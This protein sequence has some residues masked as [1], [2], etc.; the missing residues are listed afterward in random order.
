[1]SNSTVREL[2]VPYD[3][4]VAEKLAEA[5]KYSDEECLDYETVSK[6]LRAKLLEK[7]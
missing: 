4:Y 3:V 5:E 6:E 2:K 7:I 1:M